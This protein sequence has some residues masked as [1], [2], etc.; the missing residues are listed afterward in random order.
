MDVSTEK[1]FTQFKEHSVAEF[2][3]KNRQMLGFSG[4]VRSLTTIIHE[5]V[6]NSLDACEEGGIFPEI[7][8]EVKEI[9]ED[10]YWV[11]SSDNGPGIPQKHIGKALGMMLAGT[12]FHRYVQQRGQQGIGASGSTMFAQIT[13]GKPIKF[14]SYYDKKRVHGELSVDF[15]KNEPLMRNA[16]VEETDGSRHGLIVEGEFAEV[17]YDRSSF[18]VY[19][20]IKRTALVNPHAAIT[21]IEPTG[22]KITFPR[23]VDMLPPKPREIRPHPLGITTND[24]MEFIRSDKESRKIGSSLQNI[25]SRMSAGKV[26]ELAALCPGVDFERAPKDLQWADAE[27]IVKAIHSGKDKISWIAPETDAIVPIGKD[28]VEKSMRSILAPEFMA[29]TERKPKIYKGG[30]PFVV[31]AAL[32]WGGN[33]GRPVADGHNSDIMRFANRAPL[34]F[35]AGGCA[36]TE[37]IK[38]VEWKRYGIRDFENEKITVLVNLSSVHVPYTGAGKQAVATEEEVVDEVKMAVME[39][40][41]DLQ[42]YLHG[43]TRERVRVERKKAIMR[44]LKQLSAD[45][46]ELA[47]GK[48]KAADLEKKLLHLIETKYAGKIEED[49]SGDA[50]IEEEISAEEEKV[51]E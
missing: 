22:E 34:L 44:Y 13:T 28:Q 49:E 20:Y 48:A 51:D 2:F 17:K 6:T 23:S 40:A 1:I 7:T 11:R 5:Y 46:A 32:A 42:R 9:E 30:V 45:L 33:C 31:E 39:A 15:Q 24:L 19:E 8:V 4:K 14:D 29:I 3:K 12:K 21:L 10:K 50:N 26:A 41:R 36:I 27:K 38:S 25:F 43:M 16:V 47:G 37:A 18:S 35:D